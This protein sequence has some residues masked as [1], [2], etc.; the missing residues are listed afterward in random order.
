MNSNIEGYE[1][2]ENQK[3][4]WSLGNS[5]QYFNQ[6]KIELKLDIEKNTLLQYIEKVVNK[7]EILHYKMILSNG[8][9]Y[10]IQIDSVDHIIEWVEVDLN[11]DYTDLQL[12]EKFNYNY[13]PLNNQP[14]RF[15]FVTE[16]D[17]IKFIYI[18]FYS[19]WSDSYSPFLFCEY[20][21]DEIKANG[22]EE[23]ASV[24]K[25]EYSGFSSWQN[26]LIREPEAEA[27]DFWKN[28]AADYG[29][30][31]IPFNNSTDSFTP[32]KRQICKIENTDYDCL[33]AYCVNNNVKAET[34]LLHSYLKYL[35]LFTE[36]EI[37]VGYI[38]FERKY[39]EL[40]HT[41]GYVNN[42]I[43]FKFNTTI[44]LSDKEVENYIAS[45]LSSVNDWSDF[46]TIDRENKV[47]NNSNFYFKYCFEYIDLSKDKLQN[48]IFEIKDINLIQ[49]F[50]DVKLSCVDYGN[51]IA[52]EI[53][54]NKEAFE[55]EAK[56]IIDE[57]LKNCFTAIAD[58]GV[59][60]DVITELENQIISKSNETQ[61][62]FPEINSIIELFENQ[63]KTNP[64][65]IALLNDDFKITY[66]E[67][68]DKANQLKNY[69]VNH[70]DIKQGDAICYLGNATEWYVISILAILKAGAYF[71]PIDT[72]YPHERID[73]IL[74][75]SSC[76]VLICEP[77]LVFNFNLENYNVL[78][79]S[80]GKITE[81]ANSD[82]PAEYHKTDLAY[83][84]YTSGSTGKPKGCTINH[85]N[86]LNYVQWCDK[87][88]FE[89]SE[90]GNW[91]LFTSISFDLSITALF[92]SLVR[93]KKLWISKFNKEVN[94]LLQEAFCN[95]QIDTLKITPAH[96]SLLKD[97]EIKNTNI[98]KVI[99]GGEKLLNYHVEIL[100]SIRNDIEIYNEYG[101][102]E[103]TVGC[104]VSQVSNEN[105]KILIG[106]PIANTEIY[107]LRKDL[108][109]C[110]I[111]EVGEIFVA[112]SGVSNGYLNQID[113]T[114]EKFIEN[115]YDNNQKLYITG[116][117]GC[118]LPDGNIEYLGRID[119]QVKI[120]GYRIE[121]EEIEKTILQFSAD[122]A[123]VVVDAKKMNEDKM[124][125][126]YLV[127]NK[128]I[129]KDKLSH[130][131]KEKLPAYMNPGFI[132]NIDKIPLTS[133]GK[134]DRKLLPDVNVQS[135][136][137]AEY[138]APQNQ[139]QRQVA[140]IW[141]DLLKIDKIGIND[142]FIEL[143][144]HSLVAVQV[145]NRIYKELGKT[146]SL[147]V[148]F[149]NPTIKALVEQLKENQ[150]SSI[151]K[152][153]EQDSYPLTASQNRFWIM[154]QFEE[155]SL[156]YNMQT[157][158]K[159]KGTLNIVKFEEAFTYLINRHENLRTSFKVSKKGNVRQIITPIEDVR[160][161]MQFLDFS[162]GD[163]TDFTDDLVDEYFA[164]ENSIP[165]DLENA[166]LLRTTL[167]R[168]RE[169]EYVFSIALPHIIGD[170]WSMEILA[171][172]IVKIYNA[173]LQNKDINLPQLNIQYKDYAVWLNKEVQKEKYKIS[174][175]YWLK[176]FSGDLTTVNLPSFKKRP[177]IKTYNGNYLVHEFSNDFLE[178][179]N[180]FSKKHDVTLFMTLMSLINALLHKYTGNEDI[181]VGSPIAGREHPD[182]ENQVGLYLNTLALRTK[183]EKDSSFTKLLHHEKEVLLQ[184]FEHQNYSFDELIDK[185]N[186]KRDIS[187]S[188]LFDIIV[189]L[190]SQEKL[191]NFK[192]EDILDLEVHSY[193]YKNKTSKFD[194][195]F[196]F[197]E[198]DSLTLG[199]KY[200]TDIY[201][202]SF[203][204]NIFIH[205][206]E[207]MISV[208]DDPSQKI[209]ELN[210]LSDHEKRQL[211]LDFNSGSAAYPADKT[212]LDLF[213]EQLS[214][215]PSSEALV[216]DR[217]S[218]TY[219][220]L[221]DRSNQLAD[222]LQKDYGIKK[223]DPVGV[224]LSRT[225]W[226]MVSLL[227]IL[228][229]GGVYV[230]IEPQLPNSRK[231]FIAEDTG[232]NL[233]ITETFYL[234]DI[235]F[236]DKSVLA[237]D[238]EFVPQNYNKDFKI[239]NVDF[240]DF[241]YIIYTSGSTGTPKGVMINHGSLYNYLFWSRSHY[242]GR[243]LR[244]TNFGL[245]T[246]L[247]F[248]LTITSLFLPLIS[249]GSLNV[250]HSSDNV[251]EVLRTYF[252]SDLSCIKLTPAHISVLE[253]LGLSSTK[254]EVAIVG[255]EALGNNHVAALR[256]L[257]P[258]MRIYNEYGP[259]EA[260]VGCIVYEIKTEEAPILIGT[261]ISNSEIY[262]LDDSHELIGLG[263]VGEIYISGS[264]LSP[265]YLNRAD[266]TAEKFINNPFKSGERMYKTGD[267]G[268]WLPD[269]NIDYR[270]RE[271]DQVKIKG[272]RIELGEIES[273]ISSLTEEISQVVVKI[274]E[275]NNE[276]V[277]AL[278]YV[279]ET[280][281][282]KSEM[283]EYLKARLPE[284]M[285]PNYY[286][287]IEKIPLSV[288]GKIDFKAFPDIKGDDLIKKAYEAP[289]NEFEEKII[290]I[291]ANVLNCKETEIGIND[292][293][294][295][296][297]MNSINL[298]NMVSLINSEFQ[299]NLKVSA[300][301]EYPNVYE[302]SNNF[303]SEKEPEPTEDSDEN[304][305]EEIDDFLSLIED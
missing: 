170:G 202:Q 281:K 244:N 169:K 264:V 139:L 153:T 99:C 192:K 189:T 220:E 299:I 144:G 73:Y 67:L 194:I 232:L 19:L 255:G 173:L 66:Q 197:I 1:L 96:I 113:L 282:D 5:E 224:L 130:F 208:L 79:P 167:I 69:L 154:S 246:S 274:N 82:Q 2:S 77:D 193:N 70:Y 261:P 59:A 213:T 303:R 31:V 148:F 26:E 147:R 129:D 277:L 101:P 114:N 179:L 25:I 214:K 263:V 166:P 268:R 140:E 53:Y 89:N 4:L 9:T 30:K 239:E 125:V 207:L 305:S 204:E 49:D 225:D 233:L 290:K 187:R 254:V 72:N 227:G 195:E 301:F 160:F 241:A 33:K 177:L 235:D 205:F 304:I 296:L 108:K 249:G 164:K 212:V 287:K 62:H 237:V 251:S 36:E 155:A 8:F 105:F 175:D 10:P 51:S 16:S 38:P 284:F 98:K 111:G 128:I 134:I 150:F 124:L 48:N 6:I 291:I 32:E 231:S 200:N 163:F 54:L 152:I 107:I 240:Q 126:A 29:N 278:Y 121:L 56:N 136:S 55:T 257:N 178:K 132:V 143:G 245:F 123:Q 23:S 68:N 95:P 17:K 210:Y 196:N 248:D 273:V 11:S 252:E 181:I 103:C 27:V 97:V 215:T 199:I 182:L 65:H 61:N 267:L 266:L 298:V 269:G 106:K 259:T 221:E 137:R 78:I 22:N 183:V 279:S 57:Q 265:G 39:K 234:F 219:Q 13:D 271:D 81:S 43:P 216:Y 247:S 185:L 115:P 15:C 131:L 60:E 135:F 116:D 100:K 238:V 243:D 47:K 42:I 223:G 190:Q 21:L 206:G 168:T 300:L 35:M 149:E 12:D 109:P 211:L 156:A 80:F 188:V 172:E 50:F 41:V 222:S 74:Q 91:G 288:N 272:Y 88:Y 158:L 24:E 180:L 198:S 201:D 226:V 146:I 75:E 85:S 280:E 229:A 250:F 87:F 84:I 258:S 44:E 151:E 7:N 94:V 86:L 120:R 262:I 159:F 52:I 45:E 276:K 260:T 3:N 46:F 118:W 20:L 90:T 174:E 117:L 34:V 230:P 63:V 253:S 217:G 286:I 64:S 157:I 145:F 112:G 104:I 203:I 14:L 270:G 127:C 83:C 122:I 119:H 133:N 92:L 294:F 110:H 76:K 184:A 162:N 165:F 289:R 18:R 141:Q 186:F 218:L 236:Y 176:Q 228:K 40:A 256:R 275:Y 283:R 161:K 142:N 209:S 37:S 102:T 302:L 297:G 292:N 191:N 295:D 138:I 242:L 28:Y 285:I 171:V 58:Q 93:G 293:F 71:I